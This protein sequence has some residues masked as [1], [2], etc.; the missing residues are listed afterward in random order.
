MK[1][2]EQIG[3]EMIRSMREEMESG[4]RGLIYRL[5]KLDQRIAKMSEEHALDVA[6]TDARMDRLSGIIT[7][8][9]RR[10][11]DLG[12][13]ADGAHT[14]IKAQT[15]RVDALEARSA[16]KLLAS[17][18]AE[19]HGKDVEKRLTAIEKRNGLLAASEGRFPTN[20]EI[21]AMGPSDPAKTYKRTN[22][23]AAA[24][25][26]EAMPELAAAVDAAKRTIK[27]GWINVWAKDFDCRVA[28]PGIFASKEIADDWASR[29]AGRRIACIRIPDFTEGEGL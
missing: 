26:R 11:T 2:A 25:V 3:S 23:I 20:A 19:F 18:L 7:E 10:C 27:G 17:L 21:A 29:D 16:W 15:E 5:D 6:A 1:Q 28:G 9:D 24:A 22:E 12:H 8:L 14:R 4:R 13:K